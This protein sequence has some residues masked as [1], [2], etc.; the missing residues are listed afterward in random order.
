MLCWKELILKNWMGIIWGFLMINLFVLIYFFKILICIFMQ[1]IL[2]SILVVL[3]QYS[4][5]I[6]CSFF[7]KSE[8]FHHYIWPCGTGLVKKVVFLIY[9]SQSC[10]QPWSLFQKMEDP[11]RIHYLLGCAG[12]LFFPLGNHS[13]VS[14]FIYSNA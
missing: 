9:F 8:M 4:P 10:F 6:F 7:S 5:I 13:S 1:L 11:W 14:E 3:L 12:W 2:C